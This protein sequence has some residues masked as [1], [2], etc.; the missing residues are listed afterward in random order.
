MNI[1]DANTTKPDAAQLLLDGMEKNWRKYLTELERC[2]EEFS[3]E[4]I[5]DFRVAAR[6]VMAVIRLLNT[7]SPRHRLR[8]IIR[9]LKEQ[10]DD[11]DDLRDTQVILAEISETVHELPEL[12]IFQ[13]RQKRQEDKLFRVLRKKIKKFSIQE[14]SKRMRKTHDSF[15]TGTSD[16]LGPTVLQVVDDAYGITKERLSSVDQV[17]PI[18]IHRVRIAFKTFRY[19]VETVHP[20]LNDFPEINLKYMHDYQSL[21]GDVQDAEVFLQTLIDFSEHA[22]LIDLDAIHRYYERRHAEAISAYAEDMNQ[23]HT[24]WRPTPDQPFPWEKPE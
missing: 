4:A 8:K 11:L 16:D 3:N 14:L 18:T 9:T 1:N 20:L 17:R 23:L 19:M 2:R 13:E 10:L 5:H 22:S 21:M 6:R 15:L 24:F 12:Q 7:M